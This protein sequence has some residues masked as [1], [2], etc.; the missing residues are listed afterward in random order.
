MKIY[1]LANVRLPTEKAHGIQ[2]TKM[3]EAFAN[4]GLPRIDATDN[5]GLLYEDISY[6]I[7][8]AVFNV[9]NS[10]GSGYKE[11]V[12][13]KSLEQELQKQGLNFE[14]QKRLAVSYNGKK[15]GDY[16]PDFLVENKVIVELKAS[17]FLT[18]NDNQQTFYYLKGSDY[19]LALLVNFGAP[20]LQIKRLVWFSSKEYQKNPRPSVVKNQKI[21]VELIIPWRFNPIKE[22]PF[23]YYG[24]NTTD[25]HEFNN[26]LPRIDT[27]DKRGLNQ[28]KSVVLNPRKSISFKVTK[29]PCLDLI[30]FGLGKIGFLIQSLSFAKLVCLY[31]L[32]RKADIIYSRDELPL[33]FLS[34]FKKNIFWEVHNGILNFAAKRVLKKCKGIIAISQGLKDF[35]IKNGVE[36]DKILVA[37]DGVDLEQFK[38]QNSKFK[39]REDLGLPQDKKI[40]LYTGHLYEWKGATALLQAAKQSQISNLKSKILFVF[41]GGTKKDVKKFKSQISNLENIVVIGHRPHQEIPYWLKA[42]DVLVL[43][44]S[45]KEKISQLYTSPMKLFEYMASARP[46]VASDLPSLRE[47]LNDPSTGSGQGNAI[48]VKPDDP[49]A[50]AEGIMKI[51]EN[52]DLAQ[53]I[54]EKARLDV[55]NYTWQKRAEKILTFI[56]KFLYV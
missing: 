15:V 35:Y 55:Q 56:L 36:P 16:I 45:A 2:I 32:F 42:A 44:N 10:L 3:C 54:S 53:K 22:D 34:F 26:R 46:I 11:S 33:F 6:K 47:I 28:W 31:L 30:P 1:Y 8:R 40:V 23:K 48:L 38:I 49:G 37:P 5:H 14:T 52:P 27:T 50:L 18:K 39:I 4:Y 12:Y 43:P 51:L 24:I 25:N 17:K 20:K 9:Y 19:K 21:S 29:L 13:Q 41:V 7:R